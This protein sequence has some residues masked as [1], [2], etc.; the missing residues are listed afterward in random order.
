MRYI[1][2]ISLILSFSFLMEQNVY[3]QEKT[4]ITK[5]VIDAGH[6]GKDPGTIG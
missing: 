4:S 5:V 3:S 2:L 6:G 1:T